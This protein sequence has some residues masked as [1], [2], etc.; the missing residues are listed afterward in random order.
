MGSFVGKCIPSTLR[1]TVNAPLET[2]RHV[3]FARGDRSLV[4]GILRGDVFCRQPDVGTVTESLGDKADRL[5]E[6]VMPAPERCMGGAVTPSAPS[7]SSPATGA[8]SSGCSTTAEP[9]ARVEIFGD[10]PWFWMKEE[11]PPCFACPNSLPDACPKLAQRIFPP[12]S[13]NP[14]S[15]SWQVRFGVIIEEGGK[16][17][18]GRAAKTHVIQKVETAFSF[19]TAPP[20]NYPSTPVYWEAFAIDSNHQT[21][22]DYWQFELPDLTAG[23]WEKKGTL[24]LVDQLP[25]G[26]AVGNV[27]DSA[28]AP[29]TATEPKGL[30]PV[31]AT[32]RIAGRFDFTGTTKSHRIM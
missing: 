22:I 1:T 9:K 20:A 25:A 29:S 3:P 21:D 16:V 30:G 12:V 6:D 23:T 27:P 14:V 10:P 8:A 18:P 32:R 5:A 7:A 19:S 24:Y 11:K 2:L 15:F 13:T 28:G 17:K 31:M 4:R 26:M